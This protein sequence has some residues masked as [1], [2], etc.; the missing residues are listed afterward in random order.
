MLSITTDYAKDVG[1]PSPYLRSIAE[2]GFSHLHWCHQWNTDF[3][4][5]ASTAS[6][7]L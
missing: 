6:W 5:A 4:Y 1:D 2:A 7:A 3:L